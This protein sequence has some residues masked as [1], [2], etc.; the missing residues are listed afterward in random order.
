MKT[1][2]HLL[3]IPYELGVNDC[4]SAV[5]SFY[6]DVYDLHMNDY[7][8]PHN[9]WE[10]GLNLY[11]DNYA[12]EGFQVIHVP[13]HDVKE[14]DAFLI[15]LGAAF[16]THAAIYVGSNE[17]FHHFTNRLS[18]KEAYRSLWRNHTVATLRHPMVA[19]SSALERPSLDL[20]DVLPPAL[21]VRLN[22]ARSRVL[23]ADNQ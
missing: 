21:K 17:I 16:P 19:A 12:K 4:Y 7:V 13:A 9:F 23:Q 2:D 14:G 1:F 5:R 8:R 15:A 11:M 20:M 3:G 6:R 10:Y 22:E 18:C